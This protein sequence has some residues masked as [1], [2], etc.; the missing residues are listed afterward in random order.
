[1]TFRPL[2]RLPAFTAIA[3]AL[4]ALA[5]SLVGWFRP[6]PHTNQLPPTPAYTEK[7]TADAKANVCAAFGKLQRA[8]EVA[9]AVPR[10]DDAN[11]QLAAATTIRQV[12]DVFSRYLLATLA[13][14]PAAPADLATAVRK[15][16]H[17][18]KEGVIG[19]LDGLTNSDPDMRPLVD[20][21]TEAAATTR[22]LCK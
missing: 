9:K 7:Q 10:G 1:M 22:Q 11:G 16:A 19:Y 21:N 4:I 12:F 18:L 6:A 8:V 20:A 5:V 13:E 2:S 3:I 14:E 17:S 15:E